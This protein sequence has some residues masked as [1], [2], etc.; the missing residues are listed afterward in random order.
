MIFT[1]FVIVLN[2]LDKN[3]IFLLHAVIIDIIFLLL[4]TFMM[5]YIE[6]DRHWYF[7]KNNLVLCITG[8]CLLFNKIILLLLYTQGIRNIKWL[9]DNISELTFFSGALLPVPSFW[10]APHFFWPRLSLA[11]PHKLVVS[12]KM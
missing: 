12:V 4:H 1:I 5:I 7:V 2:I 10:K 8:I 11:E 3:F 9:L 6:L